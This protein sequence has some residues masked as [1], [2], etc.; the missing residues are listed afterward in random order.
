MAVPSDLAPLLEAAVSLAHRASEKIL[1]VYG[2]E[3]DVDRKKDNSPLTAADTTSHNCIIEGLAKL[4]PTFPVIS[5]E[6]SELPF[7]ERRKWE[8]YWLIDP[9]DGTK[10]FIKRNGEFTVN[11]ALIHRH[12]PILGVVDVPV[13]RECYFA[14]KGIGAFKQTDGQPAQRIRVRAHAPREIIV[15]GSRSHQTDALADYLARL[16]AHQLISV[17]SS[18]KFCLIAEGSADLYPRIG[19]TSEWDTAAAQCI[20]EQA[21]GCVT[22]MSG[23]KL[24][25]NT[26]ESFLNP[27]FLVY[28]DKSR[29]WTVYAA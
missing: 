14:A 8:T 1:H 12:Q 9:L 21:G 25:Y 17:G 23:E 10:E 22:D 11:I 13:K 7:A 3:F 18:L 2:T 24:L 27:Y 16:D 15:T 29:D 28:G 26:K 4:D 6:S 19:P 20:V 5:E